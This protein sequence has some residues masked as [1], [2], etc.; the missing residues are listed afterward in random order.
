[1]HLSCTHVS[2]MLCIIC[3]FLVR[4]NNILCVCAENYNVYNIMI[5]LYHV[6]MSCVQCVCVLCVQLQMCVCVLSERYMYMIQVQ[7]KNSY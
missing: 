1:M 7:C 5:C 4:N 3:L 2:C 6:F